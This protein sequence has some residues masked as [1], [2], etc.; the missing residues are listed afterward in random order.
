[1]TGPTITHDR[2]CDGFRMHSV[3][4]DRIPAAGGRWLY[5]PA[6]PLCGRLPVIGSGGSPETAVAMGRGHSRSDVC[7][8]EC[9]R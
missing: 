8:G 2:D 9:A 3:Y 1:M 5:V 6:C 7:H 4:A